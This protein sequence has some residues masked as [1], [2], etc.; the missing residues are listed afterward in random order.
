[1]SVLIFTPPVRYLVINLSTRIGDVPTCFWTVHK[2][3]IFQ[4]EKS[5]TEFTQYLTR[6]F[7]VVF[8][9]R[10][11]QF[12]NW[13]IWFVVP[14]GTINIIC[15]LS[16]GIYFITGNRRTFGCPIISAVTNSQC[17]FVHKHFNSAWY[18]R[19]HWLTV[20]PYLSMIVSNV[21][22]SLK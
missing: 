18:K 21:S 16:W 10:F 11:L 19:G 22:A 14:V 8:V 12:S 9:Y 13:L 2:P 15:N 17:Y 7:V 3:S 4:L 1:M 20:R 6:I 5:C